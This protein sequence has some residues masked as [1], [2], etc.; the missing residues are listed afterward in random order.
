M[1]RMDFSSC[2][3]GPRSNMYVLQEAATTQGEKIRRFMFRSLWVAVLVSTPFDLGAGLVAVR[4]FD[5]AAEQ[6]SNRVF[7]NHLVDGVLQQHDKLVKR[8]HLTLQL[9]AVHQIDGTAL[10]P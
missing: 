9:D 3:R 7:V 6:W 5:V 8:L 2:E 1:K 10:S 4:Q